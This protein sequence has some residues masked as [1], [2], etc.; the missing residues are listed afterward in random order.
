MPLLA[1]SIL[2]SI[3]IMAGINAVLCAHIGGIEADAAK[4]REYVDNSPA[5]ITAFLPV[6]GYRKAEEILKG[7]SAKSGKSIREYLEGKLGKAEVDRTLSP[8][9]LT[10]L[11]YSNDKDT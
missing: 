1:H 5:V 11:G 10:S 3:D 9:N 8:Q 2:E 4:C 7:Y 6:L